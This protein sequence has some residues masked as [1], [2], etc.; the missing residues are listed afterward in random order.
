M[1]QGE[2]LRRPDPS[3]TQ[4]S[5]IARPL[6]RGDASIHEAFMT[7]AMACICLRKYQNMAF[8]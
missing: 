8:C 4:S 3:A 5:G 6:E 1:L 2:R 7:L